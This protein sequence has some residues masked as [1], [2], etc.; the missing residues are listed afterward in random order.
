M[1]LVRSF[2]WWQRRDSN[3]IPTQSGVTL[4][5]RRK[6][7][8]FPHG[9][10]EYI[11][12]S[13]ELQNFYTRWLWK[14]EEYQSDNLQDCFDRFFTLFVAY[15]RLYAELALSLVKKVKSSFFFLPFCRFLVGSPALAHSFFPRQL[16]SHH[17][18]VFSHLWHRTLSALSKEASPPCLVPVCDFFK[19]F[20]MGLSRPTFVYPPN[21]YC[22]T[23]NLS[24]STYHHQTQTAHHLPCHPG[25][26]CHS[27]YQAH[28]LQPCHPHSRLL[29][30]NS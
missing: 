10:R 4:T 15:N 16:R 26:F 19:S 27:F 23:H 18:P 30:L 6:Y 3:L 21:L 2:K 12:I 29:Y 14:A 9:R 22:L 25:F 28:I 20:S 11:V 7:G 17:R 1:F 24:P 13:S 5:G 8:I